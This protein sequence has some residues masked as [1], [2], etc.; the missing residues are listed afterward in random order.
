MTEGI[1]RNHLIATVDQRRDEAPELRR[2]PVPTVD[3]ED[4]RAFAPGPGGVIPAPGPDPEPV[5]SVQDLGFR[6]SDRGPS[7]PA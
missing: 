4:G 3:Q 1:E 7:R 2:S 6:Y 5:A